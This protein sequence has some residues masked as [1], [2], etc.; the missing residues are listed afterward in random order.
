MVMSLIIYQIFCM[1]PANTIDDVYS[2]Q[3]LSI[4]NDIKNE[5]IDL[6][7][8]KGNLDPTYLVYKKQRFGPS[9]SKKY[10]GTIELKELMQ[11][12]I[13]K[14][15]IKINRQMADLKCIPEEYKK[16]IVEKYK[17][18]KQPLTINE[19]SIVRDYIVKNNATKALEYISKMTSNVRI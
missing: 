15:R 3:K 16:S 17:Q 12:P 11:S 7:A 4:F 18:K 19:M 5:F 10:Y 8:K 6:E 1:V 14:E 9:K 13:T 2:I